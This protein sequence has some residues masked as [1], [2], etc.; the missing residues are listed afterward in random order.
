MPSTLPRIV[1]IGGGFGG[2]ACARKLNKRPDLH[3]TLID[4][5]NHH[6][7]QPLLY[8]V[9]TSTLSIQDISRSLRTVFDRSKQA[10]QLN[11]RYDHVESIDLPTKE[12]ALSSGQKIPY[13]YLVVATGVKSSFFGNDHWQQHV[14]ELKSAQDALSIRQHVLQNLELAERR[15]ET[16]RSKLTSIVI[17]GGGPTGVELAGAFA[18]LIKRNLARNFRHFDTES[19][20]IT[21]I[22]AQDRLLTPFA[23]NQGEYTRK[24]LQ[25]Q[26][27]DV[28]LNSMVSDISEGQLTLA[29]GE[30]LKS[31]IIIWA[32]GVEATPLTRTLNTELTRNGQ[33]KVDEYLAVPGHPEVSVIGD[34]AAIYQKDGSPVPGVA[35]AATQGGNYVADKIIRDLEDDR[36]ATPF[37]YLDKGKMA[38]I[39]KG[40]AIVDIRG[41]QAKGWFGWLIW[42]FIHLLFL[43]DFRSKIGVLLSWFWAYVRNTPGSRVFPS[44]S[45]KEAEPQTKPAGP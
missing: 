38:I 18:D 41:W 19:Q 15:E 23:E 29:D 5:T 14:Y 26:G 10:D 30:I 34:A 2:L 9:A 37:S 36:R 40:S 16:D 27:V 20:S 22:E 17:V 39:G 25:D 3:V 31:D 28:R 32:A 24:H 8:Q 7:F 6:L 33:V 21:L 13:D 1:V 43:I 42:L 12:I 44:P 45:V 35:P 4:R 11:I